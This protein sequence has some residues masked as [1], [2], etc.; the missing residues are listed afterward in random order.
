MKTD[1]VSLTAH[2]TG[3]YDTGRTSLTITVNRCH[4]DSTEKVGHGISDSRD[5]YSQRAEVFM[6]H[7]TVVVLAQALEE[8]I[9]IYVTEL[10]LPCNVGPEAT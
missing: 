8:A 4:Y 5:I 2:L 1:L 3:F 9:A 7:Y 6:D 10:D